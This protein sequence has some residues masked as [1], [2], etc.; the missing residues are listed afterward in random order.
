MSASPSSVWC[1]MRSGSP[2]MPRPY[3]RLGQDGRG[4]EVDGGLTRPGERLED[5][6]RVG[7]RNVLEELGPLLERI[8][9]VP[10]RDGVAGAV[11][12]GDRHDGV[13]DRLREVVA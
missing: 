3:S 6:H 11:G 10:D 5:E 2:F 12:G 13:G 4:A 1:R 8:E 9:N 7:D